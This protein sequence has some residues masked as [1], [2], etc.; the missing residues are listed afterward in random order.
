MLRPLTMLLAADPELQA[1][2]DDLDALGP[3]ASAKDLAAHLAKAPP[4]IEA[5]EPGLIDLV[6]ENIG[7]QR[8]WP[9]LGYEPG[10]AA[11]ALIEQIDEL[12]CP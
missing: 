3:L 8:V 12:P 9:P 7:D 11:L 5:I 4:G 2:I 1:W 6:R 10:T